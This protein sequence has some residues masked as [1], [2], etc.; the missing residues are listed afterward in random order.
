M[1]KSHSGSVSGIILLALIGL[2]ASIVVILYFAQGSVGIAG[3]KTIK[4]VFEKGYSNELSSSTF[5][6]LEHSCNTNM[7]NIIASYAITGDENLESK[8][9]DGLGRAFKNNKVTLTVGENSITYDPNPNINWANYIIISKK[10]PLLNGKMK[11]VNLWVF[12]K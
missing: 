12:V 9:I 3:G 11:K 7:E 8:I 10:V 4:F 2:I 5:L 6:Q 1:K